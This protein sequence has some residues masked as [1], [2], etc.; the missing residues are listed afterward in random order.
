MQ[1]GAILKLRPQSRVIAVLFWWRFLAAVLSPVCLEAASHFLLVSLCWKGAISCCGGSRYL[2]RRS[3][4]QRR[5]PLPALRVLWSM[6]R[7]PLLSWR[8][9]LPVERYPWLSGVISVC[10][11][12]GL[13][14]LHLDCT[15]VCC[16]YHLMWVRVSL[17]RF[18]FWFTLTMV[19]WKILQ[20]LAQ[21]ISNRSEP[22]L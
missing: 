12:G 8:V 13:L 18:V 14:Q 9:P 2:L 22:N 16:G 19:A 10:D 7:V 11:H 20:T 4:C 1:R 21:K 5:V 3:H 6:I 15:L 17:L